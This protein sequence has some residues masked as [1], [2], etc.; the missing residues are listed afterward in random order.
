[1]N[2]SPAQQALLITSAVHSSTA[3]A[4]RG[5]SAT[6][7]NIPLQNKLDSFQGEVWRAAVDQVSV[8]GN[9]FEEVVFARHPELKRIKERLSR[10]GA[11][12]AA[13]TFFENAFIQLL[14][15]DSG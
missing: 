3:D 14:L 1:M 5:V 7:T 10:L 15:S 2:D 4:Y 13:M 6:L 12:P 8:D 9:D 11:K